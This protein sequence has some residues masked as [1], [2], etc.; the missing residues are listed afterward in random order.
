MLKNWNSHA[1]YQQFIILNLSNFYNTSPERVIELEPSISKLYCLNLDILR[2]ILGPYYSNTGRPATLQPEIFRSF[3][4]MLFQKETSITKW[5]K[6]LRSDKLLAMCIGCTD[7]T[8]S[9]GS[10][11]DFISRLW[12]SNLQFDRIRMK[13][14]YYYKKKPPKS[15]SP[16]KNKKLSNRRPGIVKKIRDFF[17]SGRSF[18]KRAERLLQKIFSLVA[19]EPSAELNLIDK[20]NVTIAGDGTCVHCKSSYYG[21]KICDCRDKGI[22]DCH[23]RRRLSDIDATWGWDSDENRWYYGYTLYALS[24]YNSQYK[25][26]LPVYLRF[27]EASRHD[28]VTGIVALAEFKELLPQFNITNYVLDSANDNYPTYE[29]CSKWNINPFIDLN[30]KNQGNSKYPTALTINEKGIPVCIGNHEMVYNGYEKSRS[31]HKWRC[32]LAMK[33][34]DSCS[35]AGQC[36]PSPYGRVIY[37]KP[38]WDLRMFTPVPRGSKQWK[39]IYKT[40]TCSERINNRILNNYRVHS[41]QIHGKK[42]YSFMTMIAGINIHLDARIKV[43]G[44]SILDLIK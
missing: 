23:C 20:T 11:Y 3:A 36:S 7:I 5:V 18:S 22:Y 14:T 27:V 15:K 25:I 34:I 31:R 38:S 16:G 40:R 37:T 24:V 4:L 2:E 39:V 21:T 13:K 9:L 10:H 26:D 17:E 32:P 33:K 28:S 12:C 41:L 42:R 30:S 29:L 8:P 43:S 35:C 19:V 1:D 44:F 6:K